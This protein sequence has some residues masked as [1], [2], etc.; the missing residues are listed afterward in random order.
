MPPMLGRLLRAVV[1]LLGMGLLPPAFAADPVAEVR[2]DVADRSSEARD[3]ALRRALEQAVLRLAGERAKTDFWIAP[4]AVLVSYQY[5]RA[6][7]PPGAANAEP[8]DLV[9]RF[10]LAALR[11][12]L[13]QAG[14]ASWSGPRPKVLFWVHGPQGWV[15]ALELGA[16][17]PALIEAAQAYGY[18]LQFPQLD[19]AE[20]QAVQAEDV[21]YG[22]ASRWLDASAPYGLSWQLLVTLRPAAGA[23]SEDAAR[24][25]ASDWVLAD[26]ERVVEQF[27]LPAQPLDD[28]A[29]AAWGRLTGRVLE[30]D[31]VRRQLAA[32]RAWQV[33]LAGVQSDE[34]FLRAL[35]LLERDDVGYRV[36]GA[37]PGRLLLALEWAGSA[38]E[39]ERQARAWGWEEARPEA[40][41]VRPVDLDGDFGAPPPASDPGSNPGQ[42]GS[43][44]PAAGR[45]EAGPAAPAR[46]RFRLSPR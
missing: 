32:D 8:L 18:T 22:A 5:R 27:S 41:P 15:D 9:V 19:I 28:A 3:A 13:G 34:D 16:R 36:L 2:V 11:R 7:A 6:D 31:R 17:Y 4:D 37:A 46:H 43:A 39:L 38:R 42:A 23:E 40:P 10:D 1:C 30:G 25:H 24:S 21:G 29:Q 35:S 45:A 14:F 33:E 20:R 12:E 44:R 26:G